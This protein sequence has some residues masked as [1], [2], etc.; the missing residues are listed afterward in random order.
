MPVGSCL[1]YA[2][3]GRAEFHHIW[4]LSTQQCLTSSS[5]LKHQATESLQIQ[6]LV[7]KERVSG[8]NSGEDATEPIVHTL[9]PTG[10]VE[11]LIQH[12][13]APMY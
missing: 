7:S 3:V 6:D 9:T 11:G 1:N 4:S 10:F 8:G 13:H 5:Y 2:A 12:Q